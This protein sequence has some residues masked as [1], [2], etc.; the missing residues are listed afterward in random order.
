[1]Q[2]ALIRHPAAQIEP[3]ICY[4]RLDVPLAPEGHLAITEIKAR[5]AKFSSCA[6]WSSPARRCHAVANALAAARD[7]TPYLDPRLAE[8][9]FGAWEGLRWDDVP[10]AALDQW[11][12][13]PLH[14]SPPQGETGAALIARVRAVHAALLEMKRSCIIVSHGGPLKLLATMLTGTPVDLLSPA[15]ALGSVTII[16]P[17]CILS[18]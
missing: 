11:A 1:M 17:D 5:L 18:P 9:D 13:A 3:G 6:V 2:I 10:R 7:L 8:L 4:G 14:F 12:A 16:A 15:P